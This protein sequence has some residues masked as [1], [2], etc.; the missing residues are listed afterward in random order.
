MLEFQS[1]TY[2]SVYIFVKRN[3]DEAGWL[4]LTGPD[5]KRQTV[6]MGE[7]YYRM[8][9]LALLE[10]GTYSLQWEGLT[11]AQIYLS[12]CPDLIKQG[13]CFLDPATGNA[14]D[15]KQWY[16]TPWRE[17]YHFSPFVNWVNDPNGL[18]WYQGH[19][20]LFYQSNPFDQQWDDMY[21]GHAVSRDLI[22]W[23]HLPHVLEPQP[24]LWNTTQR[25]G[26]AFSGSALVLEDGIHLY[27]TRH[28]GPLEDGEDTK[29]WQTEAVCQ[30]GI[31]VVRERDL[32]TQ[33]PEGA[34]FDFRDPKVD[35]IHDRPYLVLGG[36][37]NGNP[38]ILLYKQEDGGNW[39]YEGPLVTERTPGI[40]TFECPDF[41]ELDGSCVAAGAWM[42]HYD[43]FGRYQLTRCYVGDFDEKGFRIRQEQWYDFG[44]DFYAVQTFCHENR[45]IAIGWI[46]DFLGEH[47]KRDRGAYGSFSL[48]RELHVKGSRLYMKPAEECYQLIDGLIFETCHETHAAKRFIEGNRYYARITVTGDEDFWILL[49]ED[50]QDRLLLERKGNVTSLVSTKKVAKGVSFPSGIEN[51]RTIEIFGDRRL[52]EVF[53]NDGE[54]AG[55]KVFYQDSSDGWI[56]ADFSSGGLEKMEV[57]HM[58]PIWGEDLNQEREE[59]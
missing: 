7:D 19:Y 59:K 32:I 16:D 57:Y 30:D 8:V 52:Y 5:E 15:L 23:V 1:K 28:D 24:Y 39:S 35:K 27:L 54:A 14:V 6:T 12:D 45:R 55:A 46:S 36:C 3:Q 50:G 33:K 20:H 18:C 43:P 44:G 41:F 51:V 31:H 38:S 22:H 10:K 21:W 53:L 47:R 17:Q 42:C 29:E 25:K 49:A 34:S 11:L 9:R 58:K 4:C 2:G 26:G 48:P 56:E 37:L 40:R 13:I